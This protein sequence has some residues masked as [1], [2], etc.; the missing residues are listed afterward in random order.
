MK[1]RLIRKI[2]L[3]SGFLAVTLS[4][5]TMA[6][7]TPDSPKEPLKLQ[8]IMFDMGKEMQKITAGISSENWEQVEK[9]A[10]LIADHPK[11]PM[12]E[13]MRIM[14]FL[15]AEMGKFKSSDMKT[16]GA[17]RDLAETAKSKDGRAVISS[18]ATLQHTCLTC[19]ES[20]RKKLQ[21]HFYGQR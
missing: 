13:R 7:V 10:F 9:S 17:A 18:F 15:G 14:K 11:P 20:Y 21:D 2:I 3:A 12:S 6:E 16:H 1:R 19:H 4:N 5:Q 8:K